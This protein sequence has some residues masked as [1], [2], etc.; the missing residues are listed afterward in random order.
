MK[1]RIWLLGLAIVTVF[2]MIAARKNYMDTHVDPGEI[3]NA[4]RIEPNFAFSGVT[5]AQVPM[6][7]S[8]DTNYL[9]T[10]LN[11]TTWKFAVK[12]TTP[13]TDVG[14]ELIEREK[15]KQMSLC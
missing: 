14:Y 2:L 9:S 1:P 13:S 10:V 3:P 5:L 12:E 8:E 11:V 7:V 6:N 4:T 15:G